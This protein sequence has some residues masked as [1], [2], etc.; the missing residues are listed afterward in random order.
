MLT[1]TLDC[2]FVS[3]VCL[4][5][6]LAH[7]ICM[8]AANNLRTHL[9]KSSEFC[10]KITNLTSSMKGKANPKIRWVTS[11]LGFL[12]S[13]FPSVFNLLVCLY[14]VLG[15]PFDSSKTMFSYRH[16]LSRSPSR[17][18]AM[19][20]VEGD[21]EIYGSHPSLHTNCFSP[22]EMQNNRYTQFLLVPLNANHFLLHLLTRLAFIQSL[23]HKQKD[24]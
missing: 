10:L 8:N 3:F 20:K 12:L 9:Y 14:L 19:S 16:P 6:L 22:F 5:C 7:L 24:W 1:K 2:L 13:F 21:I 18:V 15:I 11:H 4:S 23:P 17:D